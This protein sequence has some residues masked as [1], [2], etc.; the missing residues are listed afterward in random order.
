MEHFQAEAHTSFNDIAPE[1]CGTLSGLY[2]CLQ[3]PNSWVLGHVAR[4]SCRLLGM[5][6]RLWSTFR[7][8]S[9]SRPLTV[10]SFGMLPGSLVGSWGMTPRL[11]STFRLRIMYVSRP[12]MVGSLGMSL[13][14][15]VAFGE[16]PQ[17]SGALSG[18]GSPNGTAPCRL[19]GMSPA[20]WSTFRLRHTR[21][22]LT[23]LP[24]GS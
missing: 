18:R 1:G 21:L 13:G 19:L 23:L 24:A 16:C 5:S 7:L 17:S 3:I 15:L 2:A 9:I 14:P 4:P 10:G 6:P 12:L 11:W 20:L 8:I 22:L